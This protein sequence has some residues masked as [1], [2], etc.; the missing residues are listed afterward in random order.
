MRLDPGVAAIAAV[1]M[2]PAIVD[3][4]VPPVYAGR[5]PADAR[6][7]QRATGTA[8]ALGFALAVLSRDWAPLALSAGAVGGLVALREWSIQSEGRPA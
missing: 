3:Q 2:T 4:L 8:L 5:N 1:S 7:Y 6:R